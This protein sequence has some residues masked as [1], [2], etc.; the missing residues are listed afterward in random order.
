M[1]RLLNILSSVRSFWPERKQPV[2]R[3]AINMAPR[4]TPY[5]GGNQF[6]QQLSRY[7]TFHGYDVVYQLDPRVDCILIVDGRDTLTTFGLREIR[8]FKQG[9]P[10][11][12]CIHR[13]NECDQRKGSRFMDDLLAKV[14]EVADYTVFISGWLRNYH[15]ARW[16]DAARPHSVIHNGA[17]PRVFHPLGGQMPL[18]GGPFRLVTHH[19]SDNPM[20]GFSVYQE[21]DRL[22]EKQELPGVEFWVIG[23]WPADMQW[24]SARLIGPVRGHRLASLLRQCH[25][26]VTASLW[27]PGGMHFI[28]GAQ[29]GLPVL[30]HEDGGGIVEVAE[31]FGFGFR[32][33]LVEAVN[34]LRRRYY[35]LR[36]KVLD[37]GP[38]GDHMCIAYR[39]L[40]Q[41]LLVA[42]RRIG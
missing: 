27:E 42:D 34:S 36:G 14:N 6:V 32:E 25:A 39:Q 7:L 2:A 9:C 19:W 5:G 12:I 41:L 15:S 11:V 21:I 26:Y 17:D 37:H 35:D 24:R 1:Q 18:N 38:S 16:F 30:F 20:K 10:S 29:C 28:E 23:R 8:A 40:I 31:R 4:S 33:D 13:V 3:V 22:I